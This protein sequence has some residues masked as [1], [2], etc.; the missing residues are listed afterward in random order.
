MEHNVESPKVVGAYGHY[1]V[2]TETLR[3][4]FV[5]RERA[6]VFAKTLQHVTAVECICKT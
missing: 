3:F 1:E 4:F 2:V 5:K 6:E